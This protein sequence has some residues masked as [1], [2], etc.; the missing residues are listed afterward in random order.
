SAPRTINPDVLARS[1]KKPVIESVAEK[2]TLSDSLR[3]LELHSI[4]ENPHDDG[5]VIAFLP[6]EK[7]LIEADLYT[8]DNVAERDTAS[9][10]DNIERLKLEFDTI[11]PLHGPAKPGRADLYASI[12]RPLRDM[13]E[14]LAAQAAPPPSPR[15]PAAPAS[16]GR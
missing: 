11:L 7:M 2:K 13:K 14:I 8:P 6:K 15:G 5:I 12:N 3:T 10:I 16:G 4:K 1:Q 9:F